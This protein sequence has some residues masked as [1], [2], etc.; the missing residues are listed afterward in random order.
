M[1][2]TSRARWIVAGFLLA[3]LLVVLDQWSK[4]E[5]FEWLGPPGVPRREAALTRDVH[6]HARALLAGQWLSFMTSCNPGA[7]FGQLDRYPGILVIGR[8]FAVVFL[9]VLFVRADPSHR[10]VF[11]AMLL[12]L[13]GALG[14]VIDNLWTGCEPRALGDEAWIRP[15]EVRDFIDVWFEP[16][17]GWDYHFPSFNVADSCITVGAILWVFSGLLARRNERGVAAASG[18]RAPEAAT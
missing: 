10:A 7:A 15:K 5:V 16:L 4:V 8:C 17:L 6:G 12:V 14:N 11:L 3:V 1:A 2:T 13:A 9:S 18:S